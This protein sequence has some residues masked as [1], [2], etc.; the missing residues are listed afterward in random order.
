MVCH[1]SNIFVCF[2][3]ALGAASTPPPPPQEEERVQ[4]VE[5]PTCK[6][7]GPTYKPIQTKT[8]KVLEDELPPEEAPQRGGGEPWV[9]RDGEDTQQTQNICITFV[10]R[11]NIV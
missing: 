2:R 9:G 6:F 5:E 8:F 10:Q 1:I 4:I 7:G 11:F 3:D